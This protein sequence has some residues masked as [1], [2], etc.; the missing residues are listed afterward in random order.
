MPPS[1]R[2]PRAESPR[3]ILHGKRADDGVFRDAV[4]TM[5]DRGHPLEVRVT[6]EAGDGTRL[7]R[8]AVAAGADRVIAAGGDGTVHEVARGL[9]ATADERGTEAEPSLGIV[10]LGTGNDFATAAG[11][12][13]QPL[14]ALETALETPARPVDIGLVN[15]TSFLNMATAGFGTEVTTSTPEELKQV[16]GSVAYILTGLTHMTSIQPVEARVTAPD[17]EWSGPL[18]V[19]A[20]GNSRLA[21]G[22]HRL[23]P[24]ALIDDGALD[25]RIVPDIESGRFGATLKALVRDDLRELERDITGTR[26]PWVVVEAPEGL[27][28]NLDGEPMSGTRFRFEVQP[29]RLRIHLPPGSPVIGP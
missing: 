19:L 11:I 20:V 6:W 2:A 17:F 26:A 13:D 23:C 24:E 12:S 28:V 8:E 1:G 15:E 25:V 10:P 7:A 18:L 14:E 4:R 3:V 22:G 16:L 29:D 27:H 9:I 5:R 21:G